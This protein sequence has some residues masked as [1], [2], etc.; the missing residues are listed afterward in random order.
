MA[1]WLRGV[2]M[3]KMALLLGAGAALPMQAA[4]GQAPPTTLGQERHPEL[5]AQLDAYPDVR[6]LL[7]QRQVVAALAALQAYQARPGFDDSNPDYY[8]LLGILALKCGDAALSANSFERVVLM[9]PENAGA[10]LDLAIASADSGDSSSASN[11]FDYIEQTFA[12]PPA[13]RQLIAGYRSRI[14][15]PPA[16]AAKPWTVTLQSMLGYD[17]NANS[18][19][20]NSIIR[21]TFENSPA[22]ELPLADSYRARGDAFAQIGARLRYVQP[23]TGGYLLETA[24]AVRQRTY[25]HENDFSTLDL[26]ASAGLH[27]ALAGGE[28]SGWLHQTHLTLGNRSFL[29]NTR[30]ALHYERAYGNCSAGV[31]SEA[32]WRRYADSAA[33]NG[34]LLWGQAGLACV[35]RMAGTTLQTTLIARIGNDRATGARAGGDTQRSELLAQ[36]GVPLAW[37]S[38][39][40]L[41]MEVSTAHDANGY[42][43]LLENNAARDLARRFVRLAWTVPVSRTTDVVLAAESNRVR[44]NIALFQQ[45]GESLSVEL[46]TSF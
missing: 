15:T 9:Q 38:R 32:E 31:S 29:D 6:D 7:L 16:S 13:L 42:S 5:A 25:R 44:S 14:D 27:H 24:G 23:I 35:W 28:A 19:L 45:R 22:I 36:F 21:L 18:G 43:P 34:D 30:M 17:N 3:M 33:L 40:D 46:K 2:Q 20:Q 4:Y 8:N 11:Y 1:W 26:S 39:A 10:W 37:Q 41:S 12:P